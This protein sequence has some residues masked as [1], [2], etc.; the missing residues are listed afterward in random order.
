MNAGVVNAGCQTTPPNSTYN[1]SHPDSKSSANLRTGD[2]IRTSGV[3]AS[4]PQLSLMV[5]L[6][7]QFTQTTASNSSCLDTTSNAI[8]NQSYSTD[9]Q[10]SQSHSDLMTT[11]SSDADSTST[12]DLSVYADRCD[13]NLPIRHEPVGGESTPPLQLCRLSPAA[14]AAAG[15]AAGRSQ[16][17]SVSAGNSPT[18]IRRHTTAGHVTA[19]HLTADRLTAGHLTAG[20][21]KAGHVDRRSDDMTL[22]QYGFV[23]CDIEDDTAVGLS[24]EQLKEIAAHKPERLAARLRR[25]KRIKQLNIEIRHRSS[26]S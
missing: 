3:G 15:E 2:P 1:F 24:E 13:T 18:V 14:A 10:T 9:Q 17:M 12:L 19:G 8:E 6:S 23:D 11:V 25:Q 4:Y 5:D 21:L 7:S 22:T 16:R 26:F 20:H